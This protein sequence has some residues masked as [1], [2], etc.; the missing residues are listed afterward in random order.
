MAKTSIFKCRE[1]GESDLSSEG[2][3]GNDKRKL[4]RYKIY[5]E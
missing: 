3:E 2:A 1:N 4:E 5:E